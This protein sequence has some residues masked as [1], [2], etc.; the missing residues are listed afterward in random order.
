LATQPEGQVPQA[1][2][3]QLTVPGAPGVG[4]IFEPS[5]EP[6]MSKKMPGLACVMSVMS[7]RTV[8]DGAS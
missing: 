8:M 3:G 2:Y 1:G 6:G 5:A 7:P 4:G